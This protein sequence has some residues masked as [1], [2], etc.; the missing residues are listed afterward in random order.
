MLRATIDEP[1][2]L[3]VQVA[4]GRTD[5]FARVRMYA[6]G[7]P[8]PVAIIS[9]PHIND[10]LYGSAYTLTVGG[11]FT[12]QYQVFEDPGFTIAANYDYEVESIEANSDKTNLLRLLG[13]NYH[14][15][16]M[17]PLQ[18]NGEGCLTD[19]RI[20]AYDSDTNT[21]LDDG[22]TGLLFSWTIKV[23]YTGGQLTNYEITL[24]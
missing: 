8:T 23:T 10:G 18:Y 19:A 7:S 6:L 12:A 9:L 1:I 14:N 11:F 17:T 16:I 13:L 24:D 3:Q 20:R 21:E 2:P 5:L 4:D 22:A 15:A